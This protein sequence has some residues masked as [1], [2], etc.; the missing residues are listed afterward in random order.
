MPQECLPTLP[1]RIGG[2]QCVWYFLP[3]FCEVHPARLRRPKE[4]LGRIYSRLSEAPE[5]PRNGRT[6][7]SVNLYDHRVVSAEPHRPTVGDNSYGSS[8]QLQ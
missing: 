8:L 7:R 6:Q 5:T 4:C 1:E 2:R 3:L